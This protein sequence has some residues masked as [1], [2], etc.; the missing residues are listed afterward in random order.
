MEDSEINLWGLIL[1][2]HHVDPGAEL[3]SLVG[4]QTLLPGDPSHQ[5]QFNSVLKLFS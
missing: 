4:H 2:L 1:S 5:P 3:K